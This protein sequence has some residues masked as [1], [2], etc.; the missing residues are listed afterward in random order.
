M[1]TYF[2]RTLIICLLFLSTATSINA[3]T[4]KGRIIDSYTHET[5]VG[6]SILVDNQKYNTISDVNGNY[7]LSDLPV[8]KYVIHAKSL[9][10]K[11]SQKQEIAI[12]NSTDIISFDIYLKPSA[13]ALDEVDIT[14]KANKETDISARYDE[15]IAPNVINI[16]SAKTIESLPDQ[17]VAD[18]MQRV[19][20]VSMTKNSFGS[21]SNLMV[22]GMPPRYN[23]VLVDGVSLP[24]TSQSGRTVS[25][26]IFGSELVGRIEVNKS[27]MPDLEASSIGGTVNIKMKQAPDTGY[28]KLQL[29]S[30]YNQYYFNHSI[31]TFDNSSVMAKD[32]YE[33]NG[34]TYLADES[35]F[36][37]QNLIIKSKRA[38]PDLNLNITG[39]NRFFNKKLGTMFAVG[40]QS[41]SLANTYDATSYSPAF[42]T[43]LPSPQTAEHQEFS[44]KQRRLGGYAKLDYQFNRNNQVSLYSSFFQMNELRARKFADLQLSENSQTYI[45]P[46]ETQTET[47]NSGILSISLNG[48]HKLSEKLNFDWTLLYA[49]ANAQSPDFARVDEAQAIGYPVYLN[50]SLPMRRTWQWNVDQNKTGYININYK[51]TLFDHLFLFKAGGMY[52]SK[53]RR[54]YANDYYFQPYDL[55]SPL[56]YEN[57]PNPDLLTVPMQN[58]ENNQEK[59]GNAEQNPGNYRAWEN[60]GAVYGMVNTVFWGKFQVLTGL[61]FETTYFHGESHQQSIQI[62]ISITTQRYYDLFPS[63]HLTYKLSEKQNLRLSFYRSMNRPDFTELIP[64][65]DP[66]AGSTTGNDKLK[67]SYGNCIDARY[68]IYPQREEVFTAGVFYKK[69]DNA[70]EEIVKSDDSKNIG[71]VPIP[72]T[73]YGL[74]LVFLK[75]FGNLGISANYTYTQSKISA[76]AITFII[77][78]SAVV[79]NPLINYTRTLIGQSPHLFNVSITYQTRWGF[80][81]AITYTMQG[82]NLIGVDGHFHY[83]RYQ[84]TYHNLG[85]TLEQKINKRMFINAK[86]SNLLNSPI[87]WL[88]KD[89]NNTVLRKAHNYQSYF[90]GLKF[91]F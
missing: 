38:L 85:L 48:E 35:V 10:Y 76:Q 46:I 61:R 18:I 29:A 31:Y 32:F 21:N 45:R 64:Y 91:S 79:A 54:N 59:I 43:D 40:V 75:Y 26:D 24:S 11:E 90:I 34:P 37:R 51:P 2:S 41:T 73:N 20:G 53:Y 57:Y 70:I 81:S 42:K 52:R 82:S 62:P 78:D 13:V 15:R 49:T 8:G 74:E 1:I 86:V 44:K 33:K 67:P 55:P 22:R 12:T 68:E 16:I 66:R 25:L 6:A 89:E 3:G 7:V 83:N 4:I 14:G 69:I 39:G 27:M 58:N 30:G 28:L 80:K 23:S 47:D 19:S 36:P 50:Y 60:V 9:G 71:N 56:A 5:I 84:D 88:M 65:S 77:K 17:N 63:L 72:T 87:T